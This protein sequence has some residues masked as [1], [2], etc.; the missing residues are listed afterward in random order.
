M[1]KPIK[2]IVFDLG[3]VLVELGGVSTFLHWSSLSIDGKSLDEAGLW[4]CWLVSPAVR[5]FETGLISANDF[6]DQLIDEMQLKVDREQFLDAFTAWP[7]GLYAGVKNLLEALRPN[8][9][10]ACLSNTSELHWPRLMH[11]MGLKDLLD[12]H[13]AS[14][15]IKKIKPD[16]E[17]FQHLVDALGLHPQHILFFDDNLINVESARKLGIKAVHVQGFKALRQSIQE[18]GVLQG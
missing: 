4:R 8:Y 11:E 13:F 18:L 6:A 12:H 15:I 17:C 14:H 10:L 7:S 16:A 2:A 5:A 9:K 1:K 3:G